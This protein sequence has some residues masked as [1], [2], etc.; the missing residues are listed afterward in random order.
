MAGA[1][2]YNSDHDVWKKYGIKPFAPQ[3]TAQHPAPFQH[4]MPQPSQLDQPAPALPPYASSPH[5]MNYTPSWATPM[6]KSQAQGVA[7]SDGQYDA[8][9]WPAQAPALLA[10]SSPSQSMGA[11]KNAERHVA[12][13]GVKTPDARSAQAPGPVTWGSDHYGPNI[14]WSNGD[15]TYTGGTQ[16]GGGGMAANSV[17]NGFRPSKTH[18]QEPQPINP[19][20][21]WFGS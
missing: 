4:Y 18:A 12:V 1:P 13:D 19:L 10:G 14:T 16:S 7:P 21:K 3:V 17:I 9:Q 5:G 11:A 15:K 2:K 6:M 8:A 20:K